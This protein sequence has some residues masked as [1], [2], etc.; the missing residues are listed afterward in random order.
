M[1]RFDSRSIAREAARFLEPSGDVQPEDIW[2][3]P[4][5]QDTGW[6][7][8]T[9]Y[10]KIYG[11]RATEA[12]ARCLCEKGQVQLSS[13]KTIAEFWPEAQIMAWW[14]EGRPA[15]SIDVLRGRLVSAGFQPSFIGWTIDSYR[16]VC[17]AQNRELSRY[18]KYANVWVN[19]TDPESRS[20]LVLY[21]P[22]G[23]GKT[24][25]AVAIARGVFQAGQSM[26]FIT[27]RDL[28]TLWRST[29]KDGGPDEADVFGP[30]HTVQV[31]VIDE[32]SGTKM[33]EFMID[34][35]TAVIDARQ[36]ANRPT[37]ITAN[38]GAL[39]LDSTD[40]LKDLFGASLFD[41]LRE[42]AQ[43]WPLFGESLR[44]PER[45]HKSKQKK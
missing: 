14:P 45:W 1:D 33:T 29:M 39:A 24:G 41:R 32:I 6:V 35:M 3:C 30:F 40:E 28:M 38:V 22:N 2:K 4:P 15:G 31:L 17:V 20:D 27:A 5:C 43:M 21:G 8:V 37:I 23:T 13:A 12:V 10:P 18:L 42:R 19:E 25:L 9:V 36:R 7:P 16:S 44:D 11:G 26:R 34:T